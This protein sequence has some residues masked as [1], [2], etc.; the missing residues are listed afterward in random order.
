MLG[1]NFVDVSW[2][3]DH[4]IGQD[5]KIFQLMLRFVVKAHAVTILVG[6]RQL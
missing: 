4:I 3:R 2:A 5:P 1:E 6:E